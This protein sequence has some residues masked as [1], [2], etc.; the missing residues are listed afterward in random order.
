MHPYELQI[1]E[2]M[3]GIAGKDIYN[4]ISDIYSLDSD[5]IEALIKLLLEYACW[6]TN[7]LLITISR[8]FLSAIDSKLLLNY[9]YDLASVCIDFN[10]EWESRR[11]MELSK[12]ISDEMLNW[13]ITQ[14]K[15]S[16]NVEVIEAISDYEN[17]FYNQFLNCF[18]WLW[19]M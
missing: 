18:S 17:Q 14:A 12:I 3:N 5:K 1:S 10:D 2:E 15:C 7:H 4:N 6:A 8:N 19:I 9:V 11:F 13:A 16:N